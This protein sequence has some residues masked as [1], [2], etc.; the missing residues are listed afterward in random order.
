MSTDVLNDFPDYSENPLTEGENIDIAYTFPNFFEVKT[1]SLYYIG[2]GNTSFSEMIMQGGDRSSSYTAVIPGEA[3]TLTGVAYYIEATDENANI[4]TSKTVSIPVQIPDGTVSSNME[5]SYYPNGINDRTWRMISYPADGDEVSVETYFNDVFGP[6]GDRDWNLYEW[7]GYYWVVSDTL[8]QG[9]GYWFNQWISDTVSFTMG[10]GHTSDLTGTAIELIPGW[11]L[12]SSP[13][14]FPVRVQVD[15]EKFTGLY[16]YGDY[17]GEGWYSALTNELKPWGAYAIFNRTSEIQTFLIDPLNQPETSLAKSNQNNEGWRL[18]FNITGNGYSDSGTMLGRHP[19]ALE[20]CDVFD[21]PKPVCPGEFISLSIRQPEWKNGL[22]SL[23]SD[24]RSLE[25]TNGAWVLSLDT[26]GNHGTLNVTIDVEG[27]FPAEYEIV[28]IDRMNG[29]CFDVIQ[30]NT[31]TVDCYSE[32]YR[33]KFTVVIGE[34][35]YVSEKASEIQSLIPKEFT[36]SQNYPNP[37]NPT[38]TVDYSVAMPGQ[39]RIII[40]D[41]LG[42]EINTLVNAGHDVGYHRVTWNGTDSDGMP[43]ATGV[44]LCRLQSPGVSIIRKMLLMK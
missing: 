15:P 36:L 4:L 13:Y 31:F 40:Y 5:D 22:Q 34:P 42:R 7:N 20:S 32:G 43:V 21:Y 8:E 10:S 41:M 14:L 16:S 6:P 18:Q 30:S 2:G 23:K 33:R 28:V 25:E 12:I 37:F 1:A 11:N 3:N 29:S 27:A 39:V 9:N 35:N 24:I 44:Y 26:K 19:L 38:T 17:N